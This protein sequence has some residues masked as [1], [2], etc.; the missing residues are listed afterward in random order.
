VNPVKH[1]P[2]IAKKILFTH[3]P[4]EYFEKGLAVD[5]WRFNGV[6]P[7]PVELGD[8]S[9][10]NWPML[11]WLGSGQSYYSNPVKVV[12]TGRVRGIQPHRVVW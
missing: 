3:R 8:P 1:L 5:E 4:A 7:N 9:L 6:S 11:S 12:K 10:D 2:P